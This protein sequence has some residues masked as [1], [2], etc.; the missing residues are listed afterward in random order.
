MVL[1]GM[2]QTK[3]IMVMVKMGRLTAQNGIV[4]V[5]ALIAPI[6]LAIAIADERSK[7]ERD[8]GRIQAQRVCNEAFLTLSVWGRGME[9]RSLVPTVMGI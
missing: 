2:G 5:I 7:R 3:T 4:A 8:L 6:A 9:R 1:Q